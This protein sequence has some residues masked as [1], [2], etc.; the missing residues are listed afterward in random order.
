LARFEVRIGDQLYKDEVLDFTMKEVEFHHHL[1][2]TAIV[3]L[4]LETIDP[5]KL[6]LHWPVTVDSIDGKRLF[7]GLVVEAHRVDSDKLALMCEDSSR[8]FKETRVTYGFH[9]FPW[10]EAFFY[11]ARR[12]PEIEVQEKNFPR[13]SLNKSRR[14]FKIIT[15]IV[16][17]DL[18]EKRSIL[19]VDLAPKNPASEDEEVIARIFAKDDGTSVWNQ[20]ATRAEITLEATYFDEAALEA[21]RR[22]VSVVDWLSYILR[23]SVLGVKNDQGLLLVP[24]T[25]ERGFASV[26]VGQEAYVRDLSESSVKAYLHDF[27]ATRGDPTLTLSGNDLDAYCDT[28]KQLLRLVEEPSDA[29]RRFWSALHWLRRAREAVDYRDRLLDLWITLQFLTGQESPSKLCSG[30]QVRTLS[31]HLREQAIKLG[32]RNPDL[33]ERRFCNSINQPT[34][35]ERFDILV[36]STVPPIHV[37]ERE[38]GAVWDR[39]RKARNNL[40]HG[41]GEITIAPE[42]LDVMDQMLGKII[43]VL[44][45]HIGR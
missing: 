37:D 29:A 14:R 2:R 17:L 23:L 7:R 8:H 25:R 21:R 28:S 13:L 36:S 40:E 1:E 11:V 19:G 6:N 42:D 9:G 5:S 10:Q 44:A 30:P 3:V 38:R 45:N 39:L 15:P 32:V 33:V 27:E 12:V 18:R 41:K 35:Q 20:S 16:G 4:Q 31:Q 34:L 22:V 43:W 26:S 24:W